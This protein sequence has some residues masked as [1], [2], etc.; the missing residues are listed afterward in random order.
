MKNDHQI[1]QPVGDT[2]FEILEI[3]DAPEERAR[4]DV[5]SAITGEIRRGN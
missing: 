3:P 5:A 1:G 4:V 2:L